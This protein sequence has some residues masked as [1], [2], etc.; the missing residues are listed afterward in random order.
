MIYVL[1]GNDFK[2]K[3]AYVEKL[4]KGALVFILEE[5]D[6]SKESV[7]FHTASTSLFGEKTVVLLDD[8]LKTGIIFSK[9]EIEEM[10]NSNNVFVFLEEKLLVSELNKFKKNATIEEFALKEKSTKN[11]SDDN[12]VIA[13]NFARR[14]KFGTWLSFKNAIGRGASPEEISGMLFWKN[15][16]MILS[17][18]KY[19]TQE[20]LKIISSNLVRLHHE[21]HL[22]KKDFVVG[23]EQLILTSLEKNK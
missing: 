15:K 6:L 5:N 7:L 2:K 11:K 21:A 20:E 16:M 12:F 23:L 10:S 13:D 17:S 22:G 1:I 19:F 18:T 9:K 4:S 3:S 8:F 14:N